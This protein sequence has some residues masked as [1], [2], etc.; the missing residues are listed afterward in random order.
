MQS[1]ES[2]QKKV[3]RKQKHSLMRSTSIVPILLLALTLASCT[4]V[5]VGD[6]ALA[7]GASGQAGAGETGSTAAAAAAAMKA[8][9]G[10]NTLG[11]P[12][13]D[14]TKD[15]RAIDGLFKMHM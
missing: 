7:G 12:W 15:S 2:T 8:A 5:N 11:K 6:P 4:T 14:V 10:K 13:K 3:H 1:N 9:S